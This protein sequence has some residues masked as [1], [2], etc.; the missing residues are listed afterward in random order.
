MHSFQTRDALAK[1]F[2]GVGVEVGV[3]AGSFSETILHNANVTKLYSIDPWDAKIPGFPSQEQAD[4]HYACTVAK[5]SKFGDRSFIVKQRAELCAGWIE[6]G[7]DFVYIDSSHSYAETYL[8]C[9]IWWS[10]LKPG[11]ILAGHD[12]CNCIEVRRAVELHCRVNNLLHST[13]EDDKVES[14][15]VNSWYCYK[16]QIN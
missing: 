14:F 7:L 13:T 5:L 1:Q 12:Y 9:F 3:A 6:D 10:K 15:R 4:S 2:S 11:G 8:Q 16:P